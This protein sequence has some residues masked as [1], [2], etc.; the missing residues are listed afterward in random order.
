MLVRMI[1]LWYYCK[2]PSQFNPIQLFLKL[3]LSSTKLDCLSVA[4][5]YLHSYK[6]AAFFLPLHLVTVEGLGLRHGRG[7]ADMT[8][9][10]W[11]GTYS[12]TLTN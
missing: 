12:A 6:S 7:V 5:S 1:F 9:Q 11:L 3:L 10:L 2:S 8:S 4:I